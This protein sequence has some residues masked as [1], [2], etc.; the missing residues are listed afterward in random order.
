MKRSAAGRRSSSNSSS[1]SSTIGSPHKRLRSDYDDNLTDEEDGHAPLKVYVI[2]EKLG[3]NTVQELYNLI[4][5]TPT[6]AQRV[7]STSDGAE[8]N[9]HLHLELCG[10]PKDAD[11]IVTNIR[12]K[13]RLER[14]V[15]WNTA[16]Q[17]SIVTPDWIHDSVKQDNPVQCGR[18]AALSELHDETVEHC[19]EADEEKEHDRETSELHDQVSTSSPKYKV[20]SVKPTDPRVIKNWRAKYACTRASPLV[21]VNQALAAELGVLGRSREFEGLGINALSYERSVAIREFIKNGYIEEAQT[22]RNSERYRALSEFTTIY[23]IGPS[24]ARKLYDLGLRNMD[25]LEKY[26]DVAADSTLALLDA[27]LVT[28]NGRKIVT[29]NIVPDMSIRISLILRKDFEIPIPREEVEEMHRIVMSELDKIQPGLVS[30]VVGGYR[31][32]KPQ[33]NDVDIVFSYPD[34]EKGPDIIKGLCTRFTMHLYDRDLSGFHTHDALRT[35]H[36]DSLE[37]ALTVFVLPNS[38]M[39]GKQKRLH[40]RL[41]LIFAAPEAYWT[42][43]VGWGMKFDSSGMTR[44]HD[45]KL[46]IPR[47]EQEVFSILGLDW[48]DPTMRNAGV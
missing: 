14:H 8:E 40:R 32:G 25:D 35:G 15:D 30:T 18:Y 34:L 11:I 6:S 13:K 44:R 27:S 16:R 7:T 47:D 26:Y 33:S 37:K 42:A 39:D 45:S 22:I 48:V 21:C 10:D 36:W 17:K 12:M 29:K 41:D 28:P 46:F 4:D 2:Q 31:R 9:Y 19:P 43:V 23:G 5:S 20:P 24:N 1:G 3:E 38:D